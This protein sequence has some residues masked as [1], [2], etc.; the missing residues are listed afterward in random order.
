[1][2][3][4]KIDK[5]F[6]E[7]LTSIEIKPR[8]EAWEKLSSKMSTSKKY[9][10]AFYFSIA[11][12]LLL[13]LSISIV[14]KLNLKQGEKIYTTI[15]ISK[16]KEIPQKNTKLNVEKILIEKK[17][18]IDKIIIK[19]ENRNKINSK[20][21]NE[22]KNLNIIKEEKFEEV[23]IVKTLEKNRET[24][25]NFLPIESISSI[26]STKLN[27]K[28]TIILYQTELDIPTPHIKSKTKV[29]KILTQLKRFK[30]GEPVDLNEIGIDKQ[31]LLATLKEKFN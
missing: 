15:N 24:N 12:S 3:N 30:K 27:G 28:Q 23:T 21:R 4:D 26:A 8:P 7:K 19:A 29:G 18:P 6:S 9:G 13:L 5:F 22:N 20:K 17:N 14:Y 31:T 11:A 16:I 25:L 2:E 1:M 10:H